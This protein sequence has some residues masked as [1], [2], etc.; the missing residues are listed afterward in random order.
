MEQEIS[1]I[2]G[3]LFAKEGMTR[4]L[5]LA[6]IQYRSEGRKLYLRVR[7]VLALG[8]LY[9]LTLPPQIVNNDSI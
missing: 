2:A 6:I 9:V 3:I 5:L 7:V 8:H 1:M 4:I